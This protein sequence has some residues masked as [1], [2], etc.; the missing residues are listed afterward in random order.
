MDD[1]VLCRLYNKKNAW[2]EKKIKEK[3]E[4]ENSDSFQTLESDVE[5]P[6]FDDHRRVLPTTNLAP[7]STMANQS[8]KATKEDN[9]DWFQGLNFDDLQAPF[10]A[11]QSMPGV[12]LSNQDYFFSDLSPP[13]SRSSQANIPPF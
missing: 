4:E 9:S 6:D 2:A 3:Q 1:W 13:F 12:M 8:L 7:A 11:S 5:F 10:A